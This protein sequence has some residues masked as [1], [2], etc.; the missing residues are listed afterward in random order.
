MPNQKAKPKKPMCGGSVASDAITSLVPTQATHTNIFCA[1]PQQGG[2]K[3]P[4]GKSKPK[5]MKGGSGDYMLTLPQAN[6]NMSTAMPAWLTGVPDYNL[7][8]SKTAAYPDCLS[9]SSFVFGGQ[10]MAP[11]VGG[12][13]RRKQKSTTKKAAPRDCQCGSGR[14]QLRTASRIK[15]SK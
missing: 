1:P 2:R 7:G 10:P 4:A 3:K 15:Q 11:A 6:P 12:A 9:S 13:P 14:K 8:F 5:T